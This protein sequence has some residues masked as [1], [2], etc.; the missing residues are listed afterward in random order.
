MFD[1]HARACSAW[2]IAITLC[3]ASGEIR[4]GQLRVPDL[5][6]AGRIAGERGFDHLG[7]PPRRLLLGDPPDAV[8][9]DAEQALDRRRAEPLLDLQPEERHD[10]LLVLAQPVV[11]IGCR[12]PD[13]LADR[14]QQ[15]EGHAGPLAH[16]PERLGA[17]GREPLVGGRVQERQRD[18]PAPDPLGE[19]LERDPGVL[20]GRDEARTPEVAGV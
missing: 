15:L 7:E 1:V 6:L 9:V 20:Q 19:P 2:Y 4:G 16:L 18:G 3:S 11:G 14:R 13:R 12:Q 8:A 5:P 17:E 10:R